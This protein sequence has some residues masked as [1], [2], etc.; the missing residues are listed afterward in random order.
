[1]TAK[2]FAL[3][4]VTPRFP[5][6]LDHPSPDE[7]NKALHLHLFPPKPLPSIPSILRLHTGCGTLLVS[8]ISATLRKCSSSSAH[9]PDSIPSKV[10]QRDHLTATPLLRDLRGPLLIFGYHRVS[11]KNANGIVLDKP[12]NPS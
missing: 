2:K 5:I 9:A 7:V 10:Q 6:L 3:C 1:L 8:K 4:R 12:G 11:M